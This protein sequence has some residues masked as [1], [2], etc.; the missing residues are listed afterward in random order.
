MAALILLEFLSANTRNAVMTQ[1]FRGVNLRFGLM[2]HIQ[3]IKFSFK[4]MFPR[5]FS[6]YILREVLLLASIMLVSATVMIMLGVVLNTLV[7]A[8]LG[9]KAFLQMLPYASVFS[10]Q[11]AVPSSLL[12]AVCSVYGRLA[13]DNELT[14]VK[15]A[16]VHPFRV[17]IPVYILGLIVSPIVVWINDL[18]VSWARPSINR[19]IVYSVEEVVYGWLRSQGS[20]VS[21]QGL[22]IHVEDVQDRWLI[23][24]TISIRSGDQTNVIRAKKAKISMNEATESLRIE[25]VNS[26]WEGNSFQHFGGEN[27]TVIDLP[28]AMASNKGQDQASISELS[29]SQMP[30]ARSALLREKHTFEQSVMSRSSMAMLTGNFLALDDPIMQD[31]LFNLSEVKKRT[32]RLDQEPWRR[33]ALGFSCLSFAFVGAPL[34]IHWRSA[35][36]AT[37]F[38]VCFLPVLFAYYPLYAL[39]IDRA[40]NGSWPPYSPFLPNIFMLA[41]GIYYLR[42]VYR[43]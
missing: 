39:G 25:L 1:L 9:L 8:G 26:Q 7:S 30:V 21:P 36:Y 24:A 38:F 31:R 14:A 35:N 12:F 19:I 34:A 15:S 18:A 28:L 4:H 10:L 42:K 17:I 27:P 32:A 20:Y 23:H 33:W 13:A 11:F 6:R 29:L 43:N 37:S 5:Q 40:K 16:G 2:H 41:L 3:N 22:S